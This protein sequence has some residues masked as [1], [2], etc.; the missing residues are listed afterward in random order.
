MKKKL[1][2]LVIVPLILSTGIAFLVSAL[3]IKKDGE[4]ALEE[5][6]LT[7]LRRMEA[8]RTYVANE[9][10]MEGMVK[11][12]VKK[13]PDRNLSDEELDKIKNQV[14]II[15]SWKIGMHDAEKDNYE[16]RIATLRNVAR[17]KNNIATAKELEFINEFLESKKESIT[18]K[19]KEEN[20]LWV[21]KPVYI[22]ESEN[23]LACHGDPKNSPYGDGKDILGYDMESMKDGEFRG[24][25]IIKSDLTPIQESANEA[26]IG[27]G[28]WSSILVILSGIAAFVYVSHFTNTFKKITHVITLIAS[29]NLTREITIQTSDELKIVKDG[30][31]NMLMKLREVILEV[32]GASQQITS[33]SVEMNLTSQQISDRAN[34]QASSAEEVSASMEQMV[35]SIQ[36]NTNNSQE[37]EK[38]A[39]TVTESLKESSKS[40][41]RTVS[42]METIADKIS[43]INEISQQTNLLALNAAVEAARAGEYGKG[44]AVVAGEVRELAERSHQAAAEIDEMSSTSVE[45]AQNSGK[46][47]ADMLP[48]INKNASMVREITASSLEQNAGAEQVNN[49]IQQLNQIV[50]Q[51]AA[52]AQ[53]ME[54]RS[55]KLSTQAEI[56]KK[57][58]SYFKLEDRHIATKKRRKNTKGTKA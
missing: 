3:K 43:I 21:M 45:N 55:E 35:A 29:G 12:M 58:V 2:V 17:N 38:I 16:F 44:F 57:T 37:T 31:N 34:E 15:A 36:Q 26:I 11:E 42:S 41:N 22:R 4:K 1:L 13:H 53:E 6:S 52:A 56:L 30:I 51:N 5:K 8:V 7:I 46:M 24:L 32:N 40:V 10:L 47:L 19:S 14:P 27:I 20:K 50:Q 9:G 54:E 33:A 25:F 18:Y 28:F 23:C 48:E 39:L 49:A